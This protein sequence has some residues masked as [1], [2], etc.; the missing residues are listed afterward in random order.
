[1]PA[2]VFARGGMSSFVMLPCRC[3]VWSRLI[4]NGTQHRVEVYW[5]RSCVS[6]RR[7]HDGPM[8]WSLTLPNLKVGVM[9]ANEIVSNLKLCCIPTA[10]MSVDSKMTLRS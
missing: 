5:T 10:L 8:V 2:D 3:A 9:L 1:M 6:V 4:R 7:K